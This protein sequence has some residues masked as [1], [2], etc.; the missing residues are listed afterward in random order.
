MPIVNYQRTDVRPL[1]K[2]TDRL[3]NLGFFASYLTAPQLVV[4]ES[5][6]SIA[7]QSTKLRVWKELMN[8]NV[9]L[10]VVKSIDPTEQNSEASESAVPEAT[11]SMRED[12]TDNV[13]ELSQNG[14]DD[15]DDAIAVK[16]KKMRTFLN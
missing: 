8:G 11:D 5:L 3:F 15:A 4:L 14:N 6:L 10:D 16:S 1:L 13:K 12:N 9:V 7:D 2:L